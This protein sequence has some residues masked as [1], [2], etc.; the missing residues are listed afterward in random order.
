MWDTRANNECKIIESSNPLRSPASPP[1]LN[2]TKMGVPNKT[3]RDYG[4]TLISS[5]TARIPSA[6][7]YPRETIKFT[8]YYAT[9]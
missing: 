8:H 1:N 6:P 5:P 2:N 4:I 7:H 3:E 9:L